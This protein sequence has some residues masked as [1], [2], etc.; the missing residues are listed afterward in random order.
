MRARWFFVFFLLSGFCSLVDE[1]VWLRIS[2]SHFGVG[3]PLVAIVLSV[4][5]GGRALGSLAAGILAKRAERRPPFASL[6]LYAAAEL[7][8]AASAFVVPPLLEL[9]RRALIAGEGAAPWGSA[10][11]HAAAGVCL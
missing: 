9:S 11:H 1:V 6:R 5:M 8:V 7:C 10:L 3:A 4:F 2:M